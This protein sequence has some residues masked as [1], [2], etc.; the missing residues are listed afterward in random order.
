MKQLKQLPNNVAKMPVYPGCKFLYFALVKVKDIKTRFSF[1]DLLWGKIKN[2]LI[3]IRTTNWLIVK[4]IETSIIEGTYDTSNFEPPIVSE[5]LELFM[6]KH[7]YLAHLNTNE[8]YMIVAVVEFLHFENK[9]PI[10]WLRIAQGIENNKPVFKNQ[11]TDDDNIQIV[12][13][14]IKEKTISLEYNDIEN[15]FKCL[16]IKQGIKRKKL[17]DL[18]YK[19]LNKKSSIEIP[20]QLS[21]EEK[22]I[23]F[24]KTYPN[25]TASTPENIKIN[26]DNNIYLLGEYKNKT[27]RYPIINPYKMLLTATAHK[28]NQVVFQYSVNAE[29]AKQVKIMRNYVPL[30]MIEFE[31]KIC[32]MADYIRSFNYKRPIQIPMSQLKG[33]IK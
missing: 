20:E 30:N 24:K 26:D 23:W 28:D 29:T 31:N 13:T 14:Q 12:L 32:N 22:R 5:S 4:T 15:S 21:A 3:N 18:V 11:G 1:A 10:H 9:K 16:G 2:A 6:G 33:D 25:C 27:D 17:I 7:R 19:K 8:T